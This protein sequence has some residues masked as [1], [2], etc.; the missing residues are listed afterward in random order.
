MQE[1]GVPGTH[2]RQHPHEDGNP[3]L[4][5]GGQEILEQARLVHRLGEAV[6]RPGLPLP[7]ELADLGFEIGRRR[8]RPD[9]RVEG[10]RAAER[11][12]GQIG[13]PVQAGEDP[14]QT[15]RV[16][17]EDRGGV[18]VVPEFR[19]VAGDRQQVADAE[20]MASQQVRLDADQ[21]PVAALVMEDRLDRAIPFEERGEG[22]RAHP[23]GRPRPVGHIHE[24]DPGA[25]ELPRLVEELAGVGSPRRIHLDRH[26][27]GAVFQRAREGGTLPEGRRRP[28]LPP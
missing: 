7:M 26:G 8:I 2:E 16:H 1:L 10:Q 25:R 4:P 11:V 28:F 22:D 23:G 12:P 18:R 5:D 6:V 24:P 20:R 13:A 15:Y 21:V 19:R 9:P 3:R 27:E 14:H 17:I